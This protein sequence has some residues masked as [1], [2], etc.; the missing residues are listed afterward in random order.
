MST[1][2][3]WKVVRLRSGKSDVDNLFKPRGQFPLN[4]IGR[5]LYRRTIVNIAR[6]N[7]RQVL[8]YDNAQLTEEAEKQ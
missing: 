3:V 5:A 1:G 7:D 2:T 8:V 6:Y 4:G